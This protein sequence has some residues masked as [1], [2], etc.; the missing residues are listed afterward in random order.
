MRTNIQIIKELKVFLKKAST[1]RQ[2]YCCHERAFTRSRKLSFEV[3]VL[4]ITNL[5]KKS[6]AIELDHFFTFISEKTT[7]TKGAFSQ[8]CY[9]LKA[10]FFQDWNEH[11]ITRWST[12][13][14]P[15]MRRWK[16]FQLCAMDGTTGLLPN[17]PAIMREFGSHCAAAA[18]IKPGHLL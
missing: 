10:V 17:Q 18:S 2:K 1:N 4:F 13:K 8:A 12:L 9:K 14:A 7:P 16:G 6:L 11:L 15:S 5:I 3:V